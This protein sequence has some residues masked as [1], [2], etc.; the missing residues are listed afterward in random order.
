[1]KHFIE[2]HPYALQASALVLICLLSAQ[3][4][5]GIYTNLFVEFPAGV[6]GWIVIHANL[7]AS[8]HLYMASVLTLLSIFLL[9]V[10]VLRK[11]A[12]WIAVSIGGI[13]GILIAAF[14]G[15]AF[16]GTQNDV[17][18]FFMAVGFIFAMLCYAFGLY[19]AWRRE[20]KSK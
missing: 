5:F 15:V 2:K 12:E 14:N 16:A 20:I 13:V 4:L 8:L 10:S 1:M 6:L 17:N 7:I 11:N 18:S 19:R 3:F 9:C